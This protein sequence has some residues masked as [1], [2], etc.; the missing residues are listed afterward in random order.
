MQCIF[1]LLKVDY[2]QR[3][4]VLMDQ[5]VLICG[6]VKVQSITVVN[7]AAPARLEVLQALDVA[8]AAATG[9]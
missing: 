2:A 5:H 3:K 7:V 4:Q 9:I 6:V 8:S 1:L